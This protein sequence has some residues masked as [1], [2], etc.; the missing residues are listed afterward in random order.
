MEKIYK[1]DITDMSIIDCY[2]KV[3]DIV[4]GDTSIYRVLNGEASVYK[5]GYLYRRACDIIINND[6]GTVCDKLHVKTKKDKDYIKYGFVI[7]LIR[8]GEL[9]NS[10]ICV[11]CKQYGIKIS[12]PTCRKLRKKYYL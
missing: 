11:L 2:D 12:E 1:I 3:S 5:D 4:S 8:K 7:D 9:S 10:E 6:S